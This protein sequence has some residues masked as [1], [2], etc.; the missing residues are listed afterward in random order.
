[1]ITREAKI[2]PKKYITT[3]IKNVKS[4]MV[5]FGSYSYISLRKVKSLNASIMVDIK[6]CS[7]DE[8]ASI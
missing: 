6:D 5:T 7:V 1:M 4:R 2:Q 8:K 3:T